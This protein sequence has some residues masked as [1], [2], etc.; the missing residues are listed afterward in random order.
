VAEFVYLTNVSLDGYIEDEY[1]AFDLWRAA[2][3]P[4]RTA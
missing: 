2:M 4:P 1:G 3:R